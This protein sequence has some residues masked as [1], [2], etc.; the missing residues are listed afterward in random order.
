MAGYDFSELNALVVDDFRYMR[1]LLSEVLGGFGFQRILTADDGTTAADVLSKNPIDV[2]FI[3]WNMPNL[4]GVEFT[5]G[6]RNGTIGKDPYLPILMVSGYTEERHIIAALD[7]GVNTYVL[8]PV[9]PQS[10]A[11]RLTQLIEYPP[12]FIKTE[13]Y[14]GPYRSSRLPAAADS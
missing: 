2:V 9:T 8:K 7:A 4:T 3:D 6:V 11:E 14:F 10:L 12:R 1:T 5:K 13:D